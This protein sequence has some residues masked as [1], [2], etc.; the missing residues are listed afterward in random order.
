MN[1]NVGTYQLDA[2]MYPSVQ[3]C[4]K[5]YNLAIRPEFVTKHI[6]LMHVVKAKLKEGRVHY[7]FNYIGFNENGNIV[8]KRMHKQLTK[9]QVVRIEN[10]GNIHTPTQ[11]E[12]ILYEGI[13]HSIPHFEKLAFERLNRPDSPLKGLQFPN[14]KYLD[15]TNPACIRNWEG[16][17]T[18]L[19]FLE[20]DDNTRVHAEVEIKFFYSIGGVS[21]S[22]IL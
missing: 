18:D 13:E 14:D 7:D 11:D 9:L 10:Y 2:I 17:L 12:T 3:T 4:E 1:T 6:K 21:L 8:W 22:D 5:S 20:T 15:A 16:S 19:L